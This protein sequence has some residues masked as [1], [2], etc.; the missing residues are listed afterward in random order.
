M[1][2]VSEEQPLRV[3]L[4]LGDKGWIFE[5]FAVRLAENLS[6]WNV[7]ADISEKAS[8]AAD[9]NHWMVY[10]DTLTRSDEDLS[11]RST[12]FVTHVDRPAKLAVLKRRLEQAEMGI[13]MSRMTVEDLVARGLDRRKLC[14]ITAGHD[15]AIK[16]RRI[17][18]G[19]TSRV[20]PDGAKREDILLDVA[21]MMRL[22]EFHFEIIGRGWEKV[23]PQLEAAGAT[24]TYFPGTDD[25]QADYRINIERVPHFDYYLYLAFDDGSMGFFDALAA[26]VPTIVTPIGYHLDVK[27]GITFPFGNAAELRDVFQKILGERRAR[28]DS[29]A[30]LTWDNY[31]RGHALIWR[32]LLEGRRDEI[33]ALLQDGSVVS[34]GAAKAD[35]PCQPRYSLRWAMN[36]SALYAD[37]CLLLRRYL[38]FKCYGLLLNLGRIVKGRR[39]SKPTQTPGE[40]K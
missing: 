4:V 27:G 28:A 40:P 5:K 2:I 25:G 24:V 13:C 8:A 6:H 3:C 31:A 20:R 11:L 23:I 22:E 21:R 37:A 32:A 29:V 17:K 18:L 26:G 12:M 33:P 34:A 35:S 16:P 30:R 9:F 38:G 14:F 15:G 1:T 10:L 19:I 36:R 39:R 7:N